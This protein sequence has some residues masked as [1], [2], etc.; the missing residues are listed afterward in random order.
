MVW[1]SFPGLRKVGH[2]WIGAPGKSGMFKSGIFKSC[3]FK[4]GIFRREWHK[5]LQTY[6]KTM[7]SEPAAR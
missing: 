6:P 2:G 7:G 3:I 4:S 5:K 1:L